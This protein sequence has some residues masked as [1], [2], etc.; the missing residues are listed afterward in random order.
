MPTSHQASAQSLS[1]SR[2][3]SG[4]GVGG[5]VEVRRR[6]AEQDVAHRAADQGQ[7]VTG[8]LRTARPARRDRRHAA[9][10]PATS[11]RCAVCRVSVARRS[12]AS[13]SQAREARVRRRPRCRRRPHGRPADVG[14]LRSTRCPRLPH[15]A[16]AAPAAA[17]AGGR[18]RAGL[19]KVEETSAGGLVVDRSRRARRGR[20]SSAGV[21]RRGRLLWSLP[22]GHVEAGRDRRGRRGP[23]GRGGDR[24]PRPGDRRAGHDRLLVRR[25]GPP[26]PQ[27][28]APLPARGR[29]RRALR[30][31]H[32][33][34]RG[35]LGA[36]GRAAP[37]GWR[38]PASGGW[39][40]PRPDL[41]AD[42]A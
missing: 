20:R 24:H 42:T 35:G 23:R 22:K 36:A 9:A 25:R 12:R 5:E 18:A 28:G 26:D 2:I 32:R 27:D 13:G 38:T 8:G 4:P 10:A 40:R 15:P 34:R 39:P 19:R 31:G 21:D 7:L 16:G 37:T 3:C 29:R 1:S 11:R 41:L 17:P 33:G 14:W 6:P 30:R